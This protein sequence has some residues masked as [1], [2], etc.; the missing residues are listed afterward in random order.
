MSDSKTPEAE[1]EFEARGV[2]NPRIIDLLAFEEERGEVVLSI[3]EGRPWALDSHAQLEQLEDKLNSYFNYV[4]DGFLAKEYPDYEDLPVC[5]R[6][7]C[8]AAPGEAERPFLEAAT[9]FCAAE[10]LRFEVRVVDD[11]FARR[12]DWE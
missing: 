5:I 2:E 4:L 8:V 7:D 3:L 1:Q 10:G 11:P 6:L 9:R 12:G